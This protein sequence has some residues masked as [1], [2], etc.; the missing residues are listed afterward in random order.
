MINISIN[1]LYKTEV[2]LLMIGVVMLYIHYMVVCVPLNIQ[3]IILLV[4]VFVIGVPHGALDF[5]VDEQNENLAK[6]TFSIKKFITFYLFKLFAFSLLWLFPW[7]AFSLFMVFSIY[8]FGE[9][10]MHI[11]VKNKKTVSCL[12]LSCQAKNDYILNTAVLKK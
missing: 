12:T 3:M 1:K 6:K 9:T 11:I 7:V 2:I 8:H 10:D 4:L 5:L